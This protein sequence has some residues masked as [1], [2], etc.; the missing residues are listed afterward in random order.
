[1]NTQNASSAPAKVFDG[2]VGVLINATA[3]YTAANSSRRFGTGEEGF[4]GDKIYGLAQCTPDMAMADCRS[5]LAGIIGMMPNYF[6]GKR[7]GRILGLRCNY[8]YD[9]YSFFNGV[10]LLQLPPASLGAPR[11]LHLPRRAGN[12]TRNDTYQ[13]NINRL[14]TTL[15]KNASSSRTL[16]ATESLG[17]VPDIVY[18]LALCRGDTNASA[19]AACVATAFQDAQQLCPYNKEATVFYDPC[20]IRFSNQNFIASPTGGGG[21]AALILMNTQNVSSAPAKVFDGAVG[22]LINATADYAAANSSRRFGTGEEGFGGDKIYGL[23]QC[24]PDMATAD[25]RSCLAGIIGMMPK[26]FSGKQGGRVLSLRCNYRYEIYPFF[27]GVSLLQLPAAQLGAPPAPSLAPVNMTPP[28][29]TGGGNTTGRVLAITLPIVAA[30]LATVVI[31]FYL[32]KRSER[33][34][35]PSI[36]VNTTNSEDIER[37]DSLILSIST[38]RAATD[39]FDESNKLGE[40]GFGAGVLPSDQEIAVKRL[41][42]SS[43]QGIEELKNELVLVAKLQHKNLVR[44]VGVC[45]EEQEKLLVYEYM[46]NKSLDTILFDPDKSS[47]LDWGKRFKIVNG[48]ARGLQYLHEDSQLK[49]VHRDLKASNVLLDSEFSPKI[50]DFGLARLFG[51]DQSKDVTNRVV[52]TYGY[53]A[54]EYAM[55]GHYSIKSD[56]FSFGVLILEI[57]TGRKNNV[58]YDSEQ[59]VDL[60]SLVWEHWIAGTAVELADSSMGGNCPGDQILKCI[61]I[62]LLCV[63]E[64]PTDRPMMSMVNV[65]LSSST[66]TYQAPSRPAFCIQK[67][68]V[69]SDTY[70][71]PFRGVNQSTDR[72][73]M[74][75]NEPWQ[76][77]GSGRDFS[78]KSTYQSNLALLSASLPNKA[79]SSPTLFAAGSAGA[80]GNGT[81]YALALCRGDTSNA[82]DCAGCIATAFQEGQQL[83]AYAREVAIFYDLCYL[84]FS[85]RNFLAAADDNFAAFFPKTRNVSAPAEVFDAAV[86]ALLN[87]T[88]DNVSAA[89]A[90]DTSTRRFATGVAAFGGWGVEAIYALAQCTPD[91]SPAGCRSCLAGIISWVNDPRYFSGSPTGRVLGVRC[92]YWYDVQQ[93]FPGNPLLRLE[94]TAAAPAPVPADTAQPAAGGGRKMTAVTISTS[95]ACSIVFVL[96]ISGSVL[97]FLK[98]RKASKSQNTPIIGATNK[99]ERGNCTIFDLPTLQNATNNFSDSNKLGAGGFG[100]VY[101]GKLLNGQEVAVKKLSQTQYTR[102]G[103]NQLHNEVQLLAELQHKN[104]VR[105]LGFC[106]LQDEI[107]LVYEHIKSGSL[108]NFLFS[109]FLYGF[110]PYDLSTLYFVET[111][112][113]R[114]KTLN[115]EQRY[116]IIL[117]IAKGILYLHE[118]SSIRIVHRDL[119]ANN[120]LLDENMNPKIA[121]FGLA[122]LLGGGHTQTK[123]ARVV[124]TYGYMAP[125]YALFGK[126]SPK[127]DIF[128]FGVLVL[129][130][131]TGRRNISSDNRCSVVNLLTEVWNSWSKG[132]ALQRADQSLDGYSNSRVLRCIHIGLLCVQENPVDRPSISSV[133]LMLTRRRINLRPP[134]QPAFFFGGEFSSVSQQ[135]RHRNYMY[136]KSGRVS[137]RQAAMARRLAAALL[138]AF[139]LAPPAAAQWKFCGDSAGNYTANSTYQSNLQRLSTTLPQ[140]ASASATLFAKDTLGAVPDIIYALTLC[141]GDTTNATACRGCVATAFQ[142]AQQLCPY[143]KE[144]FIVYDACYLRFSNLNFLASESDNGSP[145]I[146]TNANNATAP[147]GV[148]DAAVATLLNATTGYAAAANSSRRLGT[149]EEAF[150]AAN[151]TI[152]GL[153]QCTPDMSPDGCRR[154]LGDIIAWIPQYLSRKVGGRVIG[155]RCN[156]RYEV[157]TFFSG[158]PML[159]LPS[160]AALSPLPAP[161]NTPPP[162][163]TTTTGERK[164]NKSGTAL[165]IALPLGVVSLATVAICLCFQRRRRSRSKQQPPYPIPMVEDIKSTDS[166]FIDLST[167]RAATG[168]FSES[169]RL[170]EGGFGA[171]Y[172]GFLPNGEEIAV[173]R[174]SRSSGQG[175]EELKNE[176]VL[177]AKL[178]HKNLVRLVGVC[179]QEHEKLLVYEYMP[180][181]SIDTILFDHD[182]RK[183]LDWGKRSRIISGIARGLQYLHED[184][185][186]RIIHRDL[187]ASNVLLDSDYTPKISDFGMARLFGGDQTREITSRVV[188]TYGYM[189][190]EYAMRGHYSVKS[191]VFSFGILMI[192]IVTGRRSSG[193]LSFDQSNDLLSLVWEHWT[194]GTILE[195]MD[196]SLTNHAPRDQMLKCIHIGLLCVQDNPADRPMM[197]TVNV[198]LSSNTVSLQSPSKPSFFIPKSGTDSD[199]YSET[200]PLTSRSTASTGRSGGMSVNDVSV[201]E[202]EPR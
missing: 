88:A 186:L 66:V 104:F 182:K 63:Q 60:L 47:V 83:C 85:D 112:T 145:M 153:S 79:S 160:P 110:D 9:L 196:P 41:S 98:R 150:D 140:N 30:I 48:I 23:A 195:M 15:P 58:S 61:H 3:D 168:N 89:A 138:L 158:G 167:L 65:M 75:P 192:E 81:V 56:I 49:I 16:F 70:S 102:E 2:A 159:R 201:T 162:P 176:L 92:N 118:D 128:S 193:S 62:G 126:V 34:R 190:P 42:Q 46:P 43:R 109:T 142:D 161:A 71:E 37:I 12:Y 154:C 114:G 119:K 120:I 6:S 74:S 21:G 13:S 144:V 133:I 77:C 5:C 4:G 45:L 143:N 134:R 10:S 91:M 73:P 141:R 20:T 124:G 17:A 116:N 36:A 19:C 39:N 29:T 188:G 99:I 147:A 68:S 53:M 184:S 96:I 179:L 137:A 69:N 64:D 50:S 173:K 97:I 177:V 100:T 7:G 87:A 199:I 18:A 106:S 27:T 40:G 28:A 54:P 113:S 38:L 55:R 198:M 164:K 189:A 107:M 105:L 127:I 174:L 152:Y 44:L 172:K 52:G 155:T 157:Y 82:T 86:V 84:R 191:D 59:S 101:K 1:M 51:N 121:D 129:E 165:A 169:N 185:Q 178:Q 130:I 67:S 171:V 149:G 187:K 183:E 115:W 103:L 14:A 200:Y 78:P 35:K 156:Y 22:V 181:R 32:W 76:F 170:G 180:N 57:I 125:E 148:F 197:S 131:V 194:M 8:R 135:H 94:T 31:C 111:D 80:G 108:D 139:L 26:Y 146:L 72:S 166:L 136:D 132:T 202:L 11:R 90:A 122:R 123:T 93:F 33:A 24:T 117:G 163:P 25:C 151:P 95:V 175:I